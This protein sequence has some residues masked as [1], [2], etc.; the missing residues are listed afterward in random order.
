M[1][2]GVC[3]HRSE[4]QSLDGRSARALQ[5]QAGKDSSRARESKYNS[6]M[7]EKQENSSPPISVTADP[8]A[9]W[10]RSREELFDWLKKNAPSLAELYRGS[11]SLL[12]GPPV[13]GYTRFVSHAV[14]EI[15]NRLPGAITGVESAGRVEYK[16]RLDEIGAEW[17]RAGM[18]VDSQASQSG[19]T[20]SADKSWTEVVLPRK[21]ARK[22]ARLIDDHD[23]A[24]EKPRDT[25]VRLFEGAAPRNQRFREALRPVVVQWME[26][27]N[28][29]MERT[30]DSGTTDEK[31]DA[32]EFRRNFELFESTLLGIVHGVSTFFVNTEELD[33]ILTKG[34]TSENVEAAI[35]RMGYGEYNRYF[36]ERLE[37]PDGSVL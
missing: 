16:G 31:I 6:G 5:N 3:V 20:V 22:I 33:A 9:Y 30:H 12:F 21:L 34:P 25:A 17:K 37:S 23:A 10:T 4:A 14:R 1:C 11:V 26:V 18:V 13:P 15:R 2:C 8:V 7:D 29:F 27:C 24:R 28:W 19:A 32:N 36:F 35:A